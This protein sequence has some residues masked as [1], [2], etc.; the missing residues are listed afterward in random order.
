MSLKDLLDICRTGDAYEMF[1]LENVKAIVHG[2]NA[3][4]FH[5]MR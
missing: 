3:K 1:G 5:G 4:G 2:D